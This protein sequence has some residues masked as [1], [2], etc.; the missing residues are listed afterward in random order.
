MMDKMKHYISY[1]VF[2]VLTTVVNLTIYKLLIDVGVHYT[3]STTAAF[4]VAVIV[5]FYTNRRWVFSSQVMGKSVLKE[6]GLFFAVR[7]GTYLFDL[8][9][10]ILMIQLLHMDEFVSKLIV[11]GGVI[12]LNYILSKRVV[13]KSEA[14]A[15]ADTEV[16][17]EV[18]KNLKTQE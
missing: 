7:V 17:V 1:L 16:K 6:M 4:V 3:I 9:G 14:D 15:K 18:E 2:G 10:L 8:I 11:N 5:A 12:V 13:F